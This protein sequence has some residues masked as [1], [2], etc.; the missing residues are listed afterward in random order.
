VPAVVVTP[1]NP[2]TGIVAP[3][4]SPAP[5]AVPA[6]PLQP[7][8]RQSR[9]IAADFDRDPPEPFRLEGWKRTL[10][11]GMLAGLLLLYG[12]LLRVPQRRAAAAAVAARGI[13]RFARERTGPPPRL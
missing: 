9:P 4:L 7:P 10:V 2:F 5:P 6:S 13:G 11:G 8:P 1:M 12:L 3:P